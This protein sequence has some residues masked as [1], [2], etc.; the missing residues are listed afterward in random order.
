MNAQ[1]AARGKRVF[2][3]EDDPIYTDLVCYTLEAAG[4]HVIA[5]ADGT[6][7]ERALASNVIDIAIIDLN[8]PGV[9]G[10]TL[11]AK[12][13]AGGPNITTPI[14][15][16]TGQNDNATTLNAFRLGATSFQ[17]KPIDWPQFAKTIEQVL[18]S[19][20]LQAEEAATST[21]IQYWLTR[22]T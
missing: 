19:A 16:I 21:D 6:A 15:I 10:L 22:G 9:D 3:A 12:A 17:S 4:Y 14:V 18:R 5:V 11:V 1:G 2:L 20:L 13:R 7:A 8:L